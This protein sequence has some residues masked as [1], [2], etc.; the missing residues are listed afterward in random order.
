MSVKPKADLPGAFEVM[1]A[2]HPQEVIQ[3]EFAKTK[4]R[5]WPMVL[6]DLSDPRENL[7]KQHGIKP[8]KR[9]PC[10]MKVIIK[11]TCTPV[12]FDFPTID[13]FRKL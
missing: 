2:F 7:L 12:L 4:D 9:I 5:Q 6:N 1:F 11:G 3:E 10:I 13:Q 8:G